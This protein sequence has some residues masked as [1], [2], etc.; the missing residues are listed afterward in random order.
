VSYRG[1]GSDTTTRAFTATVRREFRNPAEDRLIG[2]AEETYPPSKAVAS[3]VEDRVNP[4]DLLRE[5][6]AWWYGE[7]DGVR[8]PYAVTGDAVRYYLGLT[9]TYRK[10]LSPERGGIKMKRTEF[11]YSATI[12]DGPTRFSRDGRSYDDVYVV[13]LKLSWFNYCGSQCACWFDLD[14]IVLLRPDGTLVC[15]FGDRKPMV[16]VS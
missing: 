5:S 1:L 3:I 16:T 9:E 7:F 8:L 12:S 13:E 6:R 14:R 11:S 15:V 10:G 2:L 4:K